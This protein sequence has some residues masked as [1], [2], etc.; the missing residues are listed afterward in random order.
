MLTI[1]KYIYRYIISLK[2]RFRGVRISPK[3]YFNNKTIFEG[4]NVV[5]PKVSIPNSNIGFGTYIGSNCFLPNCNIGRF[6]SIGK[7]VRVVSA[8]H[9]SSVFVS[10]CPVFFSTLKQNGKTYCKENRF[11]EHLSVEGYDAIIGN[12]VWIGENVIIK[13][14]VKI[15]NGA[16]VAMGSV[17][18][19]DVPPYAIVGGVPAKIIKYRFT[20]EQ[21]K[22]LEKIKWW[23]KS[24]EWIM[25]NSDLFADIDNFINK[26]HNED[27]TCNNC[28]VL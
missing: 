10:T 27:S 15:N 18:T 2:V 9:P 24:E 16:I 5:H 21:I 11:D 12:D 7:N 22:K 14:G 3:A 17:V 1:L 19:K 13:G 6:N 8:T 28:S 20:D 23:N 25:D 4:T 26:T